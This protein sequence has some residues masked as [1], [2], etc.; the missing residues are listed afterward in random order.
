MDQEFEEYWAY[1]CEL[2]RVK[3]QDTYPC[4]YSKQPK[5]IHIPS[6]EEWKKQRDL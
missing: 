6:F 3:Y 2:M 5:N 4:D 1:T